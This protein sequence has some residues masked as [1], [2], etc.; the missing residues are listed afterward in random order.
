MSI[1]SKR[2]SVNI[3]DI[4]IFVFVIQF[5]FCTFLFEPVMAA[6]VQLHVRMQ[7]AHVP[8]MGQRFG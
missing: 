1:H 2:E 4:S 3:T 5:C 8:N 7:E 6:T